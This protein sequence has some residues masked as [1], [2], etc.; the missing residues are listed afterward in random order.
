MYRYEK[1]SVSMPRHLVSKLDEL[2]ENEEYSRNEIISKLVEFGLDNTSGISDLEPLRIKVDWPERNHVHVIE[3]RPGEEII[4]RTPKGALSMLPWEGG[5]RIDIYPLKRNKA[6][7]RVSLWNTVEH[8]DSRYSVYVGSATLVCLSLGLV[9]RKLQSLYDPKR[10]VVEIPH[11]QK[12]SATVPKRK[13]HKIPK[14]VEY[15]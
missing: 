11:P 10:S 14:Q 15:V 5:D 3:L 6:F 7:D 2:A 1:I 13:R 12:T 9:P 8:K 4:M